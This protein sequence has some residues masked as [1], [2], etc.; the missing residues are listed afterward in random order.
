MNFKTHLRASASAAF[1][2][3]LTV[4]SCVVSYIDGNSYIPNLVLSYALLSTFMVACYYK[5]REALM[6]VEN[7]KTISSLIKAGSSQLDM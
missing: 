1:Y 3:L 6:W 2:Y 5:H 7:S 4:V